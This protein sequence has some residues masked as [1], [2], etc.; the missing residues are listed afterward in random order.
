M[1]YK[2]DWGLNDIVTPEHMNV[3][4][5]G[6]EKVDTE[7]ENAKKGKATLR[8]KIDELDSFAD[9]WKTFKDNGGAIGGPIT[10]NGNEV[11]HVGKK[12]TLSELGAAASTVSILAGNG[13]SGG[14]TLASNRT[15]TLGTP[16]TITTTTT[17]SV[18]T[19]SHT[20]AI[21]IG[22][23]D[24][25]AVAN[26]LSIIAGNG[27]TGGGTLSGDRTITLGTPGTI[28]SSSAN[29]VTA[30]SHTHA[31]S[32][33]A[34]DVGA[35][36][37]SGG[38]L[39]G[40][41][42]LNYLYSSYARVDG[43]IALTG[44]LIFQTPSRNS[45]VVSVREGDANGY[46]VII[47]GGGATVLGSGESHINFADAEIT[48][49]ATEILYLTSDN[50]IEF[51]TN[52]NTIANRVKTTISNNGTLNANNLQVGGY[53]VYHTNRKPSLTDLGAA[54]RT[55]TLT[56][57]NGLTGGGDLT[58][59]RTITLGTPSTITNSTTNSVTST[60]HT[61]AISLTASDVGALPISGGTTTGS[62]V[63]GGNLYTANN[64]YTG[65]N[66][67]SESS[68][69]F[70]NLG[71]GTYTHDCKIYGGNASSTTSLGAYDT[72]NGVAIWVYRAHDQLLQLNSPNVQCVN[73]FQTNRIA[74]RTVDSIYV[75]NAGN[76]RVEGNSDGFR[77]YVS[78][79]GANDS[80]VMVSPDGSVSFKANSVTRHL[81]YTN[82]NKVGGTME[83][84]GTTYG[85]SPTDSPQ[86]LIEYVE[87]DKEIDGA[88]TIYLD[89]I[90]AKMISKYAVFS[91]NPNIKIIAKYKD[92]FVVEGSGVADFNIKGQ[93]SD[94]QEY[95]K[96][97]GGFEHG[98]KE[99]VSI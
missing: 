40:N 61:H 51:V 71:T 46:G 23:G 66:S 19:S 91:S 36:S 27:L 22:P 78:A 63:V 17:N 49:N 13:L 21:S 65:H 33:T 82:G 86:S 14:G 54:S 15:I 45:A 50:G 31:I 39:T 77:F 60:S 74:G 1:A 76:C 55:L 56:A 95:F 6:L 83:I 89:P 24:I 38:T 5:A 72:G 59:N 10:I 43:N 9:S 16:S 34:A 30:T 32:L 69:H 90:Y 99:A 88:T 75:G 67:N 25:G 96:I 7:I 57:G 42:T 81:F 80:G 92:Y 12:P 11:Y 52:C 68:V 93:R 41:L 26:T 18:T 35:L 37:T 47:G 4:G 3:I 48:N 97:M 85:M 62:V 20:H 28:T 87:W 70:K 8:I 94:G 53:D 29:S 84:E 98:I 73:T 44:A 58:A 64:I 2:K 79:V